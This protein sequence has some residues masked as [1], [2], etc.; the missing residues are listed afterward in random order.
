MAPMRNLLLLSAATAAHGLHAPMMGAR[1]PFSAAPAISAF[2]PAFA[3]QHPALRSRVRSVR[4]EEAAAV[5]EP[6][7]EA[8]GGEAAKKDALMETLTTGS[9]FALWYLFNIGY[10]IYNKRALNALPIPYTMAALQLLVG[11]PYVA[12]LWATG[13][14]EKPSVNKEQLKTLVPGGSLHMLYINSPLVFPVSSPDIY[15]YIYIYI[16][17]WSLAL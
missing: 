5:P 4:M 8:S 13:L 1:A 11:I 2:R 9:Y 17:I 15:I 10:N 3:P 7:P 14:R 6:S 12:F 16:Y